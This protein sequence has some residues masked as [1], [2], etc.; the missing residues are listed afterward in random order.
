M[1]VIQRIPDG[2]YVAQPG[3]AGSYTRALQH[4]RTFPTRE[5]AERERCVEN[6][7]TVAVDAILSGRG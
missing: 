3:A 2:A 6:E 1:Y 5:A 4:A 7:I